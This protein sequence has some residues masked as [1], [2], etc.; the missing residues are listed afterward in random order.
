MNQKADRRSARQNLLWTSLAPAPTGFVKRGK[1]FVSA[2][3]AVRLAALV[4]TAAVPF[5]APIF[6]LS[7]CS[8]KAWQVC[9][10]RKRHARTNARL[11]SAIQAFKPYVL[12]PNTVLSI[13]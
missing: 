12:L 9:K 1:I 3:A 11:H 8:R 7:T 5:A 2:F 13:R 4:A 6:M 10:L